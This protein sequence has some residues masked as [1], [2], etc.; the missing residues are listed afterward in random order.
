MLD[1]SIHTQPDEE[2]CGPTSLHAVYRYYQEKFSLDE[3]IKGVER[4][5]NGGTL[6]ALLGKHALQTGYQAR[7][8]VYNMDIFDPSWLHPNIY[9]SEQLI[10][11]L[12]EQLQYKRSKKLHE[13]SQAYINFLE[14]GGKLAFKEL[15]VNLLKGYFEKKIPI[16]TGLS[17]T[18]LYQSK[19]ER[20][21]SDHRLIYDDIRG[22][23]CG[24]FVVLCGYDETKRHVVVADPHRAN[25]IS[26]D[27]YYK[28]NSSRLLNAIMLGVLTYDANLLIIEPNKSKSKS[29]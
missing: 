9:S 19:R 29:K 27:N 7:L 17:A 3:I 11:K 5:T 20:E 28:V 25:P 23:P 4:V 24:H 14:L 13:S 1:V 15:T 22:E 26:N 12:K 16:L 2:T 10:A 8:Y 21:T 18:Y 6:A